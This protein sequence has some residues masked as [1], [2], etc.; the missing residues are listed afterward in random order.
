[1]LLPILQLIN[2]QFM[3]YNILKLKQD[4]TGVIHGTTL[5]KVVNLNG[6]IDRSARQ[7]LQDI[8]PQETKRTLQFSTPIFESV[9]TYFL[10]PDVKGNAIIDIRP[11]VNR[12][13]GQVFNQDYNQQ[14]SLGIS[15]SLANQF[16]IDWN[17]GVRTIL[18]NAPLLNTG[19]VVNYAS[20][21]T[22]N[23]TWAVGGDATA[24]EVNPVN[25]LAGGGSLLFDLVPTGF[26][27]LGEFT[28]TT[29]GSGYTDGTFPTT[30]GTGT[31]GTVTITT[32]AGAVTA[33]IPSTIGSG[34]QIGD[35]LTIT[36]GAND[37]TLT[38][39]DLTYFGYLENST[40]QSVNLEDFL[41]FATWFLYTS[42]PATPNTDAGTVFPS[43]TLRFGSSPTDY[44]EVETTITQANTVFE[45]GWNLLSYLWS[46]A[47][48]VGTPDPADITYLRVTWYYD[49]QEHFGLMLNDIASRLGQ[50]FEYEYYSKYMFANAITGAFQETV[51]DDSNLINLD[52]D[53]YN[54]LFNQVAYLVAQQLQGVD[55]AA[56]DA[57]F[58]LQNYTKDVER[59]KGL[60][61][62]EK[63]KPRQPYYGMPK[64][65]YSAWLPRRWNQ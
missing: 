51:T 52:T 40:S 23:G 16:T 64:P 43:V 42:L 62:S 17:Q 3:P 58:F 13:P 2:D 12:L 29:P 18:L 54:I 6:I 33:V 22:D 39:T 41:N 61:K 57:D 30:G 53:S 7:V 46:N 34:Y 9:Y 15:G 21:L 28:I 4:L 31:G 59:Y 36:G 60:Y 5:N 49:G 20:S 8:D 48:V 1:M 63:Q 24:L 55:A 65:G 45:N 26:G 37:A 50:I 56:F 11:Q 47:T 14:F 27:G 35:V 10:A 38:I 25:F 19:V 44:Y 32:T